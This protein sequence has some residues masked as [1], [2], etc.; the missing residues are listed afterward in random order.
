MNKHDEHDEWC[1]N[2]NTR[3]MFVV[4]YILV[5]YVLF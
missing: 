3:L 2:N 4:P 1:G 5:T